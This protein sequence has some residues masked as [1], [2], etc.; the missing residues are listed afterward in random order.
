MAEVQNSSSEEKKSVE[1]LQAVSKELAKPVVEVP[2][3]L[4]TTVPEA[5]VKI[6]APVAKTEIIVD[7]PKQT[8]IANEDHLIPGNQDENPVKAFGNSFGRDEED[9]SLLY[10]RD[11][12]DKKEAQYAKEIAGVGCILRI[13]SEYSGVKTESSV[14]VPGVSIIDLYENHENKGELSGRTIAKK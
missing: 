4:G 10:Q 6:E 14:F 11:Y 13:I 12:G 7:T 2:K 1:N 3:D 8:P 9:F 5:S